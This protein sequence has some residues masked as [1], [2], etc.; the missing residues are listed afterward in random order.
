MTRKEEIA[1]CF[2]IH[3]TDKLNH[4]YAMIYDKISRYIRNVFEIGIGGG[5]SVAAWLH[6]FPYAN[7]YALDVDTGKTFDNNRVTVLH[8]DIKN[9]VP[10][11]SL[12]QFDLIVDDGSHN[13][14]DMIAG[15][16]ILHGRCKGLYVIEDVNLECF[17]E[18]VNVV[19]QDSNVISLIQT[20]EGGGSRALVASFNKVI[21]W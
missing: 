2:E 14:E 20:N 19:R 21:T 6:I 9:F 15:W 8:D 1:Y 16:K 3:Q 4:G 18:V 10:H 7:I 17:P 12:P 11:E 13:A 5:N